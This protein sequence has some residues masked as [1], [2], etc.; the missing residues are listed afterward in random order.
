MRAQTDRNYPRGSVLLFTLV[1]LVLMALLGAAIMTNSRTE[2]NITSDNAVGQEAFN[3]ADSTLSIAL[4]LTRQL[5]K[6][7]GA[8]EIKDALTPG[9]YQVVTSEAGFTKAKLSEFGKESTLPAV[10]YRYLS[11]TGA[12]KEATQDKVIL[13]FI[14][15][16]HNDEVIGT[17]TAT[18][19]N[20]TPNDPEGVGA[21]IGE[22]KGDPS[23][24]ANIKMYYV[25]T[26][27]GRSLR[28]HTGDAN[29]GNYYSG[30]DSPATHSVITTIYTDLTY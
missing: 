26:A 2:L 15:L 3:R 11:A 8:G 9:E 5:A 22:S 7:F 24:G 4:M 13:P 14:T 23:D 25:V 18:I 19:T 28:S 29:Q 16:Y 21:S 17:A 10:R 6:E 1:V 27:D 30:D 20:S 12:A